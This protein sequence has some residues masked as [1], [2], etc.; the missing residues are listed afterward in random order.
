MFFN[1]LTDGLDRMTYFWFNPVVIPIG[2]VQSG[3]WGGDGG[4]GTIT[5]LAAAKKE[6]MK[7]SILWF[8]TK[9]KN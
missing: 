7:C 4:G 2:T 8:C 9:H 6:N 5:A 1:N 3:R